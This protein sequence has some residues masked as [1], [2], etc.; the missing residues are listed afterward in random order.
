VVL[1]A[2]EVGGIA[3]I[4]LPVIF[5]NYFFGLIWCSLYLV[6][7]PLNHVLGR[8]SI[9]GAIWDGNWRLPLAFALGALMCGGCWE[10]WNFWSLPKWI[11]LIPHASF[12]RVFEM[13]VLGYG[14]YLGFGLELFAM[15]NFVLPLLRLG[16]LTID[17]G[18]FYSSARHGTISRSSNTISPKKKML[19][20]ETTNTS[21]KM[22][23]LSS[24]E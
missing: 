20:N 10:A 23:G 24:R 21:A 7:D 16:T 13:P 1:A 19:S 22:P 15:T 6:L 9:I 8:P 4:I 5:P 3:C 17:E 12:W 18:M 2:M 11:Y 14:G